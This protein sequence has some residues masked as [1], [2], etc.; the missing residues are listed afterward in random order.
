MS[1]ETAAAVLVEVLFRTRKDLQGE[2]AE[3]ERHNLD[4]MVRCL[5][6]FYRNMLSAIQK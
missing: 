3:I 6:S 4:E 2:L 5:A 1:K